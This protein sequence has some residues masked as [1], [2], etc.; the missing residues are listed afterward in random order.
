MA[1]KNIVFDVGQVLFYYRPN[2]I[3]DRLIP[4]TSFKDI[5]LRDLFG[6]PMWHAM[7]RGDVSHDEAVDRV[8]ELNPHVPIPR[9]EVRIL[10]ERFIDELVLVEENKA[11]FAHLKK[12]LPV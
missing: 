11:L 8:V 12:Q 9:E 2:E 5:Y 6:S 7:D 4:N 1:I 3:I 10:V